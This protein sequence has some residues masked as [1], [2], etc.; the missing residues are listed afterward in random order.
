[1]VKVVIDV[2]IRVVD[3]KNEAVLPDLR[4]LV[5]NYPRSKHECYEAVFVVM[6]VLEVQA[7]LIHKAQLEAFEKENVKDEN[8]HDMD[9]E[10]ETRLDETLCIRSKSWLPRFRDLREMTMYE[11]H[12]SNYSIHSG[13]DKT[14]H[15]LKQLY[16]YPNMEAGT[17]TYAT[18][19]NKQL[20][21]D[22]GNHDHQKDYA[23]VRHKPLE[24]QVGD[25]VM[26]K[27][28]SR[29]GVMHFGKREKLNHRY[30]GP[31]KILAKVGTVAYRLGLP[32][33]LSLVHST[34]RVSNLKKCLSDETQIISLDE[35]QID[36][37]FHFIEEPVEIM[38][39]EVKRLKQII[40]SIVKV[41]WNSRRGPEFTWEREDQFQ[42]KYPYLFAKPVTASNDTS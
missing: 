8:L 38:D 27:V 31:F 25:K 32:E 5:A 7:S 2:Q 26:S 37:T 15:N 9:K 28:S 33:Q 42:K 4:D 22:L 35:I 3:V 18:K 29:K 30:I 36:D 17:A 41:S 24:F 1:M 39:R 20:R 6:E 11:S 34:F 19:D 14:H 16:Q 21:H 40:I 10:F 13:S 12:K 23:N